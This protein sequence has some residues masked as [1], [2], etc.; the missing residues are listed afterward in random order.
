MRA[1]LTPRL[2]EVTEAPGTAP[3]RP[4]LRGPGEVE[5][6]GLDFDVVFVPG[7]AERLFPQKVEED[8]LL[9]R[10]RPRRASTGASRRNATARRPGASGAPGGGGA[11]RARAVLSWPRIDVEHGRPRVPSF[12]ALE[13]AQAVEGALPGY[14]AL[15]RRAERRRPRPARLARAPSPDAGHRCH[16]VRSRG[17]GG[18]LP[19][20]G[21]RPRAGPLPARGEPGARARAQGE[22]RPVEPVEARP[23]PTASSLPLSRRAR[24]SSRTSSAARP[25]SPTALEQYAACPYR[26]FLSAIQRLSPLEIP[27]EVEELGPLEKGSMTHEVLY[28]LLS[29]LRD[30]GTKV[31]PGT[32]PAVF[33]ELDRVIAQV[34]EKYAD[35]F[36]PA[37]EHVWK[38][39]VALLRAD[40][41]EWLRR[42]ADDAGW[43]PWRFELGFGLKAREQ[44][45]PSSVTSPVPLVH[46]LQLRGSIDL[47]ELSSK[48]TIRA[49]DYKTGRARAKPGNVVGGGKHLQPVLYAL[50][51]EQLLPSHPIEAGR[52]SYLTQ[53]GGFTNVSTPLDARA[54]EAL[55]QVVLTIRT[56]LERGFFPALPAEGECRWCDYGAVCG[57]DEERRVRQTKKAIRTE[58]EPLTALRRLP[59]RS[60]RGGRGGRSGVHRLDLGSCIKKTS[61]PGPKE[62]AAR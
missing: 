28:V 52:L 19:G 34:T 56:A 13:A 27:G 14:E 12:Y 38:D 6:L 11:A 39:G 30:A 46:G 61:S 48:G 16:R 25:F 4:A 29:R 9:L 36:V 50:V 5:V 42:V 53:I 57:P 55:G 2:S 1:V 17:A 37:I 62:R 49:T 45:D 33:G 22:V 7:L 10:R 15:Q 26:F 51:L 20:D 8:P 32:L 31:S 43:T 23:S 47:V 44:Q 60:S 54:R 18:P 41:R 58:V 24:P 35:D 59:C 3:L 21:H 40:L